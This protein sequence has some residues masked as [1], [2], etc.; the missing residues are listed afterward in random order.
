MV[1]LYFMLQEC[2]SQLQT[3]MLQMLQDKENAEVLLK[4]DIDIASRRASLQSRLKRLTQARSYLV[5]F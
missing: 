4:E 2:A 1:I 5:G 3:Q